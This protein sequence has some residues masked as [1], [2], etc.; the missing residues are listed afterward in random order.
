MSSP[1]ASAR[2][3]RALSAR[4]DSRH[5]LRSI[6]RRRAG[7]ALRL[8]RDIRRSRGAL[9]GR[10]CV[11]AARVAP[12]P[13]HAA[14]G[15]RH[16]GHHPLGRCAHGRPA[17]A[18]LG[19]HRRRHRVSRG[20][21]DVRFD[22]FHTGASATAFFSRSGGRRRDGHRLRGGRGA[23]CGRRKAL[24]RGAGRTRPRGGRR[25][26]PRRRLSCARVRAGG[27]GEPARHSAHHRRFLHAAQHAAGQRHP[28]GARGAGLGGVAVCAVSG[29][30]PVGRR[31]A[32]GKWWMPTAPS[33]CSWP[34]RWAWLCSD[35][36]FAGG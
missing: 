25:A 10:R 4:A 28:D 24:R 8:A 5:R 1:M 20:H 6:G 16:H 35:T 7:R 15:R 2:P 36:V 32:G 17:R 30:R 11:A 13:D 14:R 18:A 3:D 33:R 9:S 23:V 12:Q 21:D 34:R 22:R 19:P 26:D 31:L 27:M 29:Y